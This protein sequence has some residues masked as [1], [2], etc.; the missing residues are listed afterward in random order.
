MRKKGLILLLALLVCLSAAVSAY[1]ANVFLFTER[2]ITLFEGETAG[3]ALDREGVYEG[4][5]EIVYSSAKKSIATISEEGGITA[6]S[7]G[8]TTVTASLMRNGKR[9]GRAQM[10]VKV[11]RAVTKVTLN[12][13][14]LSVYDPED[15]AVFD[16]LEEE[17]DHKVLVVP[18]GSTAALSTTCT[19]ETASNRKVTYSSTDEGIAKV[20]GTN[21]KAVQ[22]GECD[23]TISSVQN[24][25]VTEVFHVLVIQPVKK[26]QIDAGSKK[27]AAGSRLALKATCSPDNAT[28]QEV[29]WSSSN[30]S[31]A[32]V[33]QDGVVTG[34]KRGS[35]NI[36]ATAA[37]GSK[38][39]TSAYLTVT[40]PV[41]EITFSQEELTVANGRSVQAKVTVQPKDAS[42]RTV[43]WT[44]SDED[45]AT[46]KGGQ[47][48]G[49][50]AGECTVICTSN[51]NPEI[52][53]AVKVTVIQ[54]ATK[55]EFTNTQSELSLKTGGT[56]QLV[57]NVLPDDTT[58][59]GVTLKS[60]HPKIATVDENG[61]VTALSR[62]TATIVAT[63]RDQGKKQGSVKITV[64]QPVTGVQMQQPLY[65]IQR[66]S[67][68]TIRAVVEPRNANNQKIHWSSVDETIATVRSNGT[69][70]G[71]VYGAFSGTTTVTAYTDDGGYT[72][73]TQIR[74][75]NFNEAVMVEELYVNQQ[76][77]IKIS[78]RNM[79]RDL[80]MGNVHY[81]IEC[82]DM[83]GEPMICNKDGTGTSFEGD[84]P[85]LL[86]PLDRTIHGYFRFRNYVIDEP[87]GA[88][89]LTITSWQ[90]ADGYTWKIP[91]NDRIHMEWTSSK[92][93]P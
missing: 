84:Y 42:D 19:P 91:E 78:L 5:G 30:A 34:K 20:T 59:K 70:T 79:S 54:L 90:D 92:I 22:R 27:V 89:V 46:V 38:V 8:E 7:K 37:D 50:K 63:S 53:A 71:S 66:G 39:K 33:N 74:V 13:T 58:N 52:S 6:V 23:L 16:I 49:H 77:Q 15:P 93:N 86:Y 75:G 64:I 18:A 29:V 47:I 9:V 36:T 60:Q 31:I 80:T 83:N 56:V 40:Q 81:V 82:F 3:T 26:I 65:Y 88:V 67:S 45:I 51:S 73:E 41:T 76:N 35:V 14:R 32:E 48:T 25:E 4:D 43:S 24:P 57:W 62:G 72:A 17:T 21:L 11:L 68:G 44:S 1:A 61:F 85:F 2:S 55:I 10:T 12:T 87:I 28:I 69:S